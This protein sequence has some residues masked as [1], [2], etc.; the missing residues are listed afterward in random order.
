MDCNFFCGFFSKVIKKGTQ[1]F[2][3]ITPFNSNLKQCDPE[4]ICW[5]YGD[6]PQFLAVGVLE[7]TVN[8]NK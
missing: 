5:V 2:T 8:S 3:N 7:V 1:I 4:Y 6:Q